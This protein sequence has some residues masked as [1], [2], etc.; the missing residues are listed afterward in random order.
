MTNIQTQLDNLRK[1]LRQYEYEYHVLDNP[2]VPDSEYDRL[3]HQLKALELEHP[4]FLTVR[5]AHSTCWC[6]TTFLGLAKFVTK[7]LCSL[8]IMLFPMQEFNAFVKRIEDR[9]IL[10]PKP[11]TFCLRT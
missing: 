6:K 2:S 11:L 9:L 3:F 8:W 1:T 5:F 7:F 10:L 4:E